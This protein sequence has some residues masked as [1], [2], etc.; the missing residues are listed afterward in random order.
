MT[1][2]VSNPLDALWQPPAIISAVLA[3][4]GLALVLALSPGLIGDRWVYFGLVSLAIQWVILLTLGGLY[5]LR[6]RLAGWS[7]WWLAWLT[8]A[9]LLIGTLAVMATSYLLLR[10]IWFWP[11]GAWRS[12]LLQMFGIAL[13]VGLFALVAFQNYWRGRQLLVQSQQA[14]LEA[15]Q[16]RI[17]PH[18]LFNT[19]NTAAA[20]VHLRPQAAEQVLLDLSDLFRAALSRPESI[21]LGEEIDLARRYLAIEALRLG[22]RLRVE[23]CLPAPLPEVRVPSL[24]LQPLVEN[25]VKHGIEP[26]SAGGLLTIAVVV[27]GDRLRIEVV[28][29]CPIQPTPAV[30]QGHHLG[31][32][33]IRARLQALAGD[34]A[35]LSTRSEAGRYIAEME[36]PL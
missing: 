25:A 16:A 8:L 23:W 12:L 14:E 36:L 19:L 10:E 5:L 35:R 1:P 20:L 24:S 6:R 15:L 26:S 17:R 21:A 9:L 30:H 7:A 4:E 13:V 22:E 2:A 29:D 11:A 31:Q 28:N 27:T 32:A 3:G 33:S 34:S 18:F